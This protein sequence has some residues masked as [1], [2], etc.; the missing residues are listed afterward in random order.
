MYACVYIHIYIYIST[1]I[2]IYI[3]ITYVYISLSLYLSLSLYIYIY[4]IC[5][6]STS[7]RRSQ[8]LGEGVRLGGREHLRVGPVLLLVSLLPLYAYIYIYTHIFE[9]F[10]VFIVCVS[11][12]YNMLFIICII[13]TILH[14]KL[15][16]TY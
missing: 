11:L 3:H 10:F 13:N 7:E 14:C 6:H 4:N 8:V 15:S 1:Y 2:Y 9:F 12:S 5:T 16:Y